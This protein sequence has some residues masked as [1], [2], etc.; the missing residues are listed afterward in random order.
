MDGR[1]L[2]AARRL[3]DGVEANARA[4]ALASL[5][6][7][8]RDMDDGGDHVGK[9]IELEGALVRHN[10]PSASKPKP[11]DDNML[12]RARGKV[13]QAVEAASHALVSTTRPG[14]VA[15]GASVHACCERVLGRK[16]AGLRFR[17]PIETIMINGVRHM[18][19][20]IP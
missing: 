2:G 13:P 8:D 1:D 4:G 19:D 17:Q 5:R 14:M 20:Y 6:A 16:V 10:R 11:T 7:R 15:Q 18:G 3:L 9:V 12:V